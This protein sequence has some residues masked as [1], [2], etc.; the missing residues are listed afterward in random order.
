MPP[1]PDP[2]GVV[3]VVVLTLLVETI[4]H[5]RQFVRP[6]AEQFKTQVVPDA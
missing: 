1:D 3:V 2:E 4:S 5:E 6:W